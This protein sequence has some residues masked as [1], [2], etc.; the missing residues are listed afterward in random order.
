MSHSFSHY[1]LD[2]LPVEVRVADAAVEVMDGDRWLWYNSRSPAGVGLAAPV[3]RL[4][5]R[6]EQNQPQD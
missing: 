5:E 1:D 2:M 3:S 6:L 4:L